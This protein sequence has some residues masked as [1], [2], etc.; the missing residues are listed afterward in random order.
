MAEPGSIGG[1]A[2]ESIRGS[3]LLT[4]DRLIAVVIYFVIHVI[5]VRY[6]S[7]TQYGALAYASSAVS[8]GSTIAVF[9]MNKTMARFVPMYERCGDYGRAFGGLDVGLGI[10]GFLS[11]SPVAASYVWQG[12]LNGPIIE[13]RARHLSAAD[14]RAV[15]QRGPRRA[16]VPE[17]IGAS[18][19][20]QRETDAV[21]R[22]LRPGAHPHVALRHKARV[23][24][25]AGI[26]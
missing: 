9:G 22:R 8:L 14:E 15:D 5:A 25:A 12:L 1:A 6:L 11:L 21:V 26:R 17:I 10:M 24:I 18:H 2:P 4:A 16:N 19:A 20:V 23:T 13:K 3:S 7:Q